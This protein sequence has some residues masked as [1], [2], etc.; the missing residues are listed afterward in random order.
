MRWKSFGVGGKV[1]SLLS[2]PSAE[3]GC[4]ARLPPGLLLPPSP[5]FH[6][7]ARAR[8]HGLCMQRAN[9]RCYGGG[10][11]LQAEGTPTLLL[12]PWGSLSP[13]TRPTFPASSR[14]AADFATTLSWP[15]L[16][17]RPAQGAA[18]CSRRGAELGNVGCCRARTASR[19]PLPRRPPVAAGRWRPQPAEAFNLRVGTLQGPKEG[20]DL[21]RDVHNPP[22]PPPFLVNDLRI[23]GRYSQF[24]FL[25]SFKSRM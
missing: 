4:L 18:T 21:L 12:R 24:P 3:R 8:C 13:G 15:G 22:G 23:F 10:A 11:E 6:A 7:A 19:P 5:S 16:S 17:A 1:G 2:W 14:A 9:A 20:R 25:G